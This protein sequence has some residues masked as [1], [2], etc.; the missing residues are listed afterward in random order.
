MDREVRCLKVEKVVIIVGI[1]YFCVFKILEFMFWIIGDELWI[2]ILVNGNF[3]V[4][5]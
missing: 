2:C 4:K 1:W 3:M 5:R